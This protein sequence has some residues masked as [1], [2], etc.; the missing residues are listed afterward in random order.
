ML[1]E[2]RSARASATRMKVSRS[3]VVWMFLIGSGFASGGNFEDPNVAPIG[4]E[5]S[6]QDSERRMFALQATIKERPNLISA[7]I[8]L[9]RLYLRL[10]DKARAVD[11]LQ[12]AV[13]ANP[14][15]AEAHDAL[16]NALRQNGELDSAILEFRRAVSIQPKAFFLRNLAQALR[17]QHDWG[18]ALDCHQKIVSLSEL[19]RG[20][21]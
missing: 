14:E 10:G 16:G 9:G 3:K 12:K 6:R 21:R 1:I 19:R 18:G 15:S 13:V 7:Q 20:L 11:Q 17:D 2:I 8:E 4:G 5:L